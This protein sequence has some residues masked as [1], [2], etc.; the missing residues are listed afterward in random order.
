MSLLLDTHVVLWWLADDA[1]LS[2]DIKGRLD[3]D[4][5]VWVSAVTAW[6]VAI[7]ESLGKLQSRADLADA[8]AGSG[9]R[10][11]GITVD[12]AIAAGRLPLLHRDPFDRMLV[13]R[14]AQIQ[15]Y[16]VDLL[17]V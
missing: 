9:F 13:T 15:R 14:D 11:L 12:H 4:P 16:D 7:K 3:N 8:V 2:N 6:E 10:Q 1:T 5:N 17:Q